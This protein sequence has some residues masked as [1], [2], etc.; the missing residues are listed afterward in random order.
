MAD[1]MRDAERARDTVADGTLPNGA[2]LAAL[3]SAGIGAF[4]LGLVV[5]LHEVG[6]LAVPALYAPAGGA[7]G[8]TA[9]GVVIWVIAWLTL[10]HLWKGREIRTGRVQPI[11]A[12]LLLLGIAFTFPPVWGLF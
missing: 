8:R 4:T 7:S 9:I 5:I 1:A 11:T 2:A 10:H 12:I 6:G 3:L